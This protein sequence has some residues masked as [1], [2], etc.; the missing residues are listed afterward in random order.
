MLLKRGF[1]SIV[2]TWLAG[3]VV[4]LPLALTLAALSWLIGLLNRYLGPD[5]SI[6]HLF[7]ALG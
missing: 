2:A 7:S 5:S 4:F 6:G 1:D 3:L